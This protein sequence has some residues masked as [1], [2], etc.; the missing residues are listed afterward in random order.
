MGHP[1]GKIWKIKEPEQEKVRVLAAELNVTPLTAKFLIN[2]DISSKI[3]GEHFMRPSLTSL[4]DPFLMADIEKAAYRIITACRGDEKIFIYADYDVDGATGAAALFLFI[5]ALFP[6]LHVYIHQND[7]RKDGYG[8]KTPYIQY[9]ARSGYSLLITV[10]CGISN[11]LEVSEARSLDL[12]VI[13]TDHH[14]IGVAIPAAYAVLNP[15]REDCRYPFK[16]L[17]GVGVVFALMCVIRKVLREE[18]FF[19]G[20]R[21]LQ[22]VNYL[23]LVSLGTVVD[24]SPLR[25]DNRIFVRYGLEQMRSSPRP[26]L[27]A[28]LDVSGLRGSSV[29]ETDLG[30]R[31]GPRLNA[32]GRI[33]DSTLSSAILVEQS[34]ERSFE[35]A[36]ILTR[37]N[38][39]RQM[40]E[41]KI[42]DEAEKKVDEG[43]L[44]DRNIII[45]ASRRWHVGVVGIVASKLMNR[46]NR[47]AVLFSIENGIARGSGRSRDGIDILKVLDGCSKHITHYGGHPMAVGL[48]VREDRLDEF[49][50]AADREVENLYGVEVDLPVLI[51]DAEVSLNEMAGSF[52]KELVELA[53]FGKGNPEPLFLARG[54]KLSKFKKRHRGGAPLEAVAFN[55]AYLADSRPGRADIVFTPKSIRKGGGLKAKLFVR[56]A[57][58]P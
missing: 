48:T 41:R 19:K 36:R 3:E 6:D 17:A 58:F 4:T 29:D 2:R 18:G 24:M 1:S 40:E 23:D 22:L 7:R 10:D 5:K 13:V 33:G 50:E 54:L 9:A 35:L 38:A 31:V 8:V 42:L 28:L 51:V 46:Y 53:P 34:R 21:E 27:R 30:F 55:G 44:A 11:A 49:I 15:N 37:E 45:S 20:T 16:G 56:D 57:R 43:G 26:G 47:P 12:D 14:S 52:L 39:R 32:A 25:G